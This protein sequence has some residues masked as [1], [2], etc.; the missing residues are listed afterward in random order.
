[1]RRQERS[2]HVVLYLL[3][4][5][6]RQTRSWRDKAILTCG[7]KVDCDHAEGVASSCFKHGLVVAMCCFPANITRLN[8]AEPRF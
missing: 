7:R 5:D 4:R 6:K 1:M 3:P 8:E 2:M